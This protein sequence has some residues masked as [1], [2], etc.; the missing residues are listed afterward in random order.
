[1]RLL[2]IVLC[3]FGLSVPLLA[4]D[5]PTEEDIKLVQ[6]QNATQ[7]RELY[8]AGEAASKKGDLETAIWNWSQALKLKP[9]SAYTAKCLA[10][11]REQLYKKYMASVSPKADAKDPITA[12]ARANAT[13]SL[14]PE[15]RELSARADKLKGSLNDGQR[16]ALAAYEEGQTAL[17]LQDY[18]RAMSSFATAET[19][20]R[21]AVCVLDVLA[22]M[23][24]LKK[25]QPDLFLTAAD[26][27]KLPRLI[28][29][30]TTWCGYCKKMK[31]AI[32]EIAAKHGSRLSV[33]RIDAEKNRAAAQHYRSTGYPTLVFEDNKGIE[34]D[35]IPGYVE[36]DGLLPSLSK[37]GIR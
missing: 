22:R 10:Q 17:A 20:A 3:L 7:A 12:Y 33:V 13:L 9:D 34:V 30:Y 18:P 28:Y 1:M 21:D 29:I 15:H 26:R 6:L 24:A 23:D 27:E 35:R 14:L 31:P 36:K 8:Q 16:K 2:I 32:D 37:L 5:L 25:Q 4:E 11:A 19:H